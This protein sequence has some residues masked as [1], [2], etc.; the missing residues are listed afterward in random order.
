MQFPDGYSILVVDDNE[1]NLLL[2][3]KVLEKLNAKVSV[4]RDGREAVD[5]AQDE[6]FDVVLMDIQMPVMDGFEASRALRACDYKGLIIALSANVN[7]EDLGTCL[8]NGM[9]DFVGKPFSMIDIF[10]TIEKLSGATFE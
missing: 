10:N 8:S 4:A 6:H 1:I 7:D 2:A 9:N 5:R 3:Q